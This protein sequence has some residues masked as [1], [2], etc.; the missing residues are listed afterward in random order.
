MEGII[1]ALNFFSFCLDNDGTS[2]IIRCTKR[3]RENGKQVSNNSSV[4][5]ILSPSDHQDMTNLKC[6]ISS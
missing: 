3:V 2:P 4:N 5:A 1:G 6:L